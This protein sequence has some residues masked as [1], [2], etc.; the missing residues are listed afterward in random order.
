MDGPRVP[1]RVVA[2][3]GEE[4]I[5]QHDDSPSVPLSS[6]HWEMMFR[7]TMRNRGGYKGKHQI[8]QDLSFILP[9]TC[10]TK[11]LTE[12]AINHLRLPSCPALPF[13]PVPSVFIARNRGCPFFTQQNKIT[14][15]RIC[16]VSA[17]DSRQISTGR[18]HRSQLTGSA[19]HPAY[20]HPRSKEIYQQRTVCVEFMSL[21]LTGGGEKE[22]RSRIICH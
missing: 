2:G 10:D 11:S 7:V 15:N 18:Q 3:Q 20:H 14:R 9:V 6:C 22:I 12:R 4:V 1:P 17:I 19:S 16:S 5:N 21:G 13:I 8:I